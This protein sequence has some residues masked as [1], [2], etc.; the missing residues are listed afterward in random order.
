MLH[1]TY[2]AIFTIHITPHYTIPYQY[3]A[4]PCNA[5][6][7]H[8]IPYDTIR[9]YTIPYHTIPY[10]KIHNITIPYHRVQI[11]YHNLSL[12]CAYTK[13]KTLGN[14]NNFVPYIAY[15]PDV[16]YCPAKILGFQFVFRSEVEYELANTEKC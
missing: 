12:T 11:Q 6:P 1:Q 13:P 16:A 8:T 2:H 5:M 7:C 15:F 9:Y 3:H 10:H 4:M 14:K